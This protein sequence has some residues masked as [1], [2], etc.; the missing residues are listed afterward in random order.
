[1]GQ[2]CCPASPTGCLTWSRTGLPGSLGDLCVHALLFDPG[3]SAAPAR[4]LSAPLLPSV[5]FKTSAPT[6]RLSRL[7]PT[8]C[9]LAVYAS[10]PG[11]PLRHARLASGWGPAFP[12][13]ALHPRDP[14]VRF[15]LSFPTWLPP[16]PGFSWRTKRSLR[17]AGFRSRRLRATAGSLPL[18]WI[19]TQPNRS[20]GDLRTAGARTP[21]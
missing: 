11:L 13:R 19:R 9:T 15:L 6:S 3:G 2:G 21:E 14:F 1:M 10:Q 8:A 17:N 4:S 20:V 12:G 16:H 18:V 7:N 5:R